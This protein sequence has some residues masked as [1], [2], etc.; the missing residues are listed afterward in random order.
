MQVPKFVPPIGG[1][2]A[3]AVVGCAADSTM[4][5]GLMVMPSYFD[6]LQCSELAGQFHAASQRIYQ[7]TMLRDKAANEPG[8]AVANALAYNTEYAKAEATKKYSEAAANRKGC[9]LGKKPAVA[10]KPNPEVSTGPRPGGE[11]QQPAFSGISR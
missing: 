6:T 4:V 2:V 5:E 1:L 10:A 9:D 8:G 11:R 7:L 3:L